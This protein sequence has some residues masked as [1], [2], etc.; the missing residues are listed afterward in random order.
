[1]SGSSSSKSKPDNAHAKRQ[2]L[3]EFKRDKYASTNAVANLLKKARDDG[4]PDHVS[5]TT[6]R[7][8]RAGLCARETV[9]GPI[10][11]DIQVPKGTGSIQ[12][13]VQHPLAMLD[14]ASRDCEPLARILQEA[15]QRHGEPTMD[16]PWNLVWYHDEIGVN[17]LAPDDARKT[18]GFYW[19]FAEFGQRLL[20]TDNCWF[21]ASA[22]RSTVVKTISG[23]SSHLSKLLLTLFFKNSIGNFAD[24]LF[25][26]LPMRNAPLTFFGKLGIVCGDL[27]A[28]FK[29]LCS[30]GQNANVPCPLHSNVVSLKS[31]W[32]NTGA[33]RA[34]NCLELAE[35]I[36]HTDA[37]IRAV[38]RRVQQAAND[39]AAKRIKKTEFDTLCTELGW[40][41]SP[42]NVLHCTEL[43]FDVAAAI[44]IDWFHTYLQTGIFNYELAFLFVFFR[45]AGGALKNVSLE[46]AKKFASKF[47]WPSRFANPSQL[48]S[49]DRVSKESVHFKCSGSEA[50]SLYPILALFLQ[51]VVQP[52]GGCDAQIA[53]FLALCDVLDML[54]HVQEGIV[55]ADRLQSAIL[56]HLA[57]YKAAY[58][59]LG[60]VFKFH[61]ALHLPDQLRRLG[62]LIAL[63]TLERRHKIVKR[64]VHDRRPNPSFERGL[65]EDITLQHLHDMRRPWWKGALEHP[66]E[67]THSM[68]D[69]ILAQIPTAVSVKVARE[70][71]LTT[72]GSVHVND[73]VSCV[74]NGMH[75]VGEL[76]ILASVTHSDGRDE[77]L[78]CVSIWE[79]LGGGTPY[80]RDFKKCDAPVFLPVTAISG[81]CIYCV[82]DNG[83]VAS[84]LIPAPLRNAF[85]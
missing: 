67:P 51:V 37:T 80:Y 5:A 56:N 53:S 6:L 44:H 30:K 62:V 17:P 65:I 71:S 34:F 82:S 48:L 39:Y 35:L 64:Y 10:V 15:A 21:V 24:G 16:K 59:D 27:D 36:P 70:G 43:R 1:M 12:L 52:L 81:T 8:A 29:F 41:H 55:S 78:A 11:Q 42:D 45:H 54:V 49:K 38:V 68:R 31:G 72:I 83:Q 40:N 46:M 22:T 74:A 9:Y 33:L 69:A 66:S 75:K 60:W 14:V 32:A 85:A 61:A 7:R 2:R 76:W 77:E 84:C 26:H 20:C 57:L 28:L 23:G 3:D 18:V 79:G 47:I 63:F 73:V 19:S 13:A 25:L 58:D 4:I 50:L